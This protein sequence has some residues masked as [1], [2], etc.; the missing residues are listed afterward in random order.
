MVHEGAFPDSNM[1]GRGPLQMPVPDVCFTLPWCAGGHGLL[2]AAP[3]A[4]RPRQPPHSEGWGARSPFQQ[5]D[6][7]EVGRAAPS[8]V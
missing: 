1:R 4:T 3:L 2:A 5:H 8:P 6:D 7:V